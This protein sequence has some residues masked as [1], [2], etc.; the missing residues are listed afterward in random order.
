MSTY[1]EDRGRRANKSKASKQQLMPLR[2]RRYRMGMAHRSVDP[3][4]TAGSILALVAMTARAF[5]VGIDFG[6]FIA[7]NCAM[8]AFAVYKF[9]QAARAE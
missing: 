3:V 9:A 2:P 8:A 4:C 6:L 7:L 5:M 1:M